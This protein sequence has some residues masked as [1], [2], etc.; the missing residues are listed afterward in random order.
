MCDAC[1]PIVYSH[2]IGPI[3]IKKTS[4]V[5]FSIRPY[6]IHVIMSA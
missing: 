1:R 2:N 4:N 5:V 6:S 3:D